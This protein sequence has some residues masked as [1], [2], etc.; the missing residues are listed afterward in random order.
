MP[1]PTRSQKPEAI[2]QE[3]QLIWAQ[4]GSYNHAT[5]GD[6]DPK[7]AP[8]VEA[9]LHIVSTGATVVLRPGSGGRS[10]GVA[11][12]EG[13]ARYAPTWLYDSEELD[14]WAATVLSMKRAQEE[15][16]AD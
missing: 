12:W 1:R 13:D 9:L 2:T 15:K 10:L 6:F 3:R 11:I 7:A 4:F 16:A 5:V 14:N 8:L